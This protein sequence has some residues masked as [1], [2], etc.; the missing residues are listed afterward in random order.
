MIALDNRFDEDGNA[1]FYAGE[2]IA[3]EIQ[4]QDR[5]GSA[6]PIGDRRFALTIHR[7]DRSIVVARAAS[8]AIDADGPYAAWAIEGAISGALWPSPGVR[9]EIAELLQIGRDVLVAGTLRILRAPAQVDAVEGPL[10][11]GGAVTRFIV[12]RNAAGSR[13]LVSQRGAPGRDALA[14][15]GDL[16][17]IFENALI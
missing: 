15:P 14:D 3:A 9:Y 2:I 11:D 4:L 12:R 17:V 5:D 16:R 7:P 13:L 1:T 8:A 10:L 6:Q